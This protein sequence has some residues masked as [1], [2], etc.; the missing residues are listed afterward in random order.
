MP[1]ASADEL[2]VRDRVAAA[3]SGHGRH[4][5]EHQAVQ[6]VHPVGDAHRRGPACQIIFHHPGLHDLRHQGHGRQQGPQKRQSRQRER[7]PFVQQGAHQNEKGRHQ[8]NDNDQPGKV[9]THGSFIRKAISSSS[10]VPY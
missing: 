4:R 2:G 8:R 1:V 10:S 6:V 5:H 7:Q 9:R 3:R